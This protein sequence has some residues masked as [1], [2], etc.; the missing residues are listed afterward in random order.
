MLQLRVDR[1]KDEEGRS[2]ERQSKQWQPRS[3][4]DMMAH[5]IW[6]A[7]DDSEMLAL[8]L[9]NM[10]SGAPVRVH[11]PST[12]EHRWGQLLHNTRL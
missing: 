3:D 5:E 11:V 6:D 9:P 7:M 1:T 2:S 4:N 12:V 10:L 8:L